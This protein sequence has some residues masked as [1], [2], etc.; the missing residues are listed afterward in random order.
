MEPHKGR[1]SARWSL[2]IIM[3][4]AC[5]LLATPARIVVPRQYNIEKKDFLRRKLLSMLISL[6]S[7]CRFFLNPSDLLYTLSHAKAVAQHLVTFASHSCVRPMSFPFCLG[8]LEFP[9]ASLCHYYCL[10]A[11]QQICRLGFR[12]PNYPPYCLGFVHHSISC[13]RLL[14]PCYT[15]SCLPSVELS[16]SVPWGCFPA[17]HRLFNVILC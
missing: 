6:S 1:R 5:K 8:L 13:N 11:A 12:S 4:L 15:F 7:S 2:G 17:L 14:P 9:L 16:Q 10:A 3:N